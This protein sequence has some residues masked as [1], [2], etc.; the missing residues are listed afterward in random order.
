MASVRHIA[1]VAFFLLT[2]TACHVVEGLSDDIT[3]AGNAI[4]SSIDTAVEST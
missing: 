1:I 4:E 2:I 3:N